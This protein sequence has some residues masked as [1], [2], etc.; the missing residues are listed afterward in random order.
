MSQPNIVWICADDFTPYLSG[1]YGNTEIATPNIDRLATQGIKFTRAYCNSPLSTPSRQTFWTGRY[2]HTIGVTRSATPLPDNEVTIPALLKKTGYHTVAFGKTHY[3]APRKHE[4]DLCADHVEY[5][6]WLAQKKPHPIPSDI[7]VLGPWHPFKDPAAV[8]LNSACLPYGAV[9]ADMQDTFYATQAQHYLHL[10]NGEH[11]PF[12]LYVSFD[13]NHSPF[14][15]P[16]EF[17]DRY[18]S[19]SLSVPRI[20]PQDFDRIPQVF[21][22]LRE[23]E[24]QGILAAYYTAVEY[25]DKNVGIVLDALDRSPY[26]NNTVVIF[27]NDHGYMLGEHGRF[28]KHCSYEQAVRTAL[29]M[30]YPGQIPA[31]LISDSLVELIDL[32]PTLLELC[33]LNIPDNIQGKSLVPLL[34]GDSP[35]HRPYVISTYSGNEEAMIRTPRWKLVYGTGNY[36]RK[37]GYEPVK[38]YQ[39]RW[40]QLFDI[41][42]DPAENHNLAD[43]TEQAT[44]VKELIGQLAEHMMQIARYPEQLPKSKDVRKILAH[45]LRANDFSRRSRR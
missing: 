22:D 2:P 41:I 4:F 6:A 3:Y 11:Q 34:Q 42:Q 40:L 25:M 37:D 9:D 36:R 29:L 32:V 39:G 7:K 16:I 13:S 5:R 43:H 23:S 10:Q 27:N 17:R 1:T 24:K 20:E 31:G 44:M 21:A 45:C 33:Q 28:E 8:W 35:E 30:R 14:R 19:K 12:F 18:R 15:F 38:P 26:A